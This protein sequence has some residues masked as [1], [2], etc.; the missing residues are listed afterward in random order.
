M[1]ARKCGDGNYRDE[2]RMPLI[3]AFC[4][5]AGSGK[6]HS[7]ITRVEEVIRSQP[8]RESQHV[9]VI[10]FMHGARRQLETRFKSLKGTG[11]LV[12]CETI[13]SFCL[14]IINHFRRYLQ[15]NAPVKVAFTGAETGWRETSRGWK[16]TLDAMRNGMVEL[17]DMPVV[18]SCV[19]ATYPLIVVDEFQDCSTELLRVIQKLA[20]VS[21]LFVA[22]DP[23]QCLNELEECEAVTW[24]TSH[25][26][27]NS[28]SDNFRTDCAT[29][30][31]TAS[32]LRT[33]VACE[34][35]VEV[36]LCSGPG[37]AAWQIAS[38]LAWGKLSRSSSR[39]LLS[40]TRPASGNWVVQVLKSL[41]GQLGQKSKIGPFP[42]V[43]E[44]SEEDEITK[45]REFFDEQLPCEGP[46][47]KQDLK[48][49]LR[50]SHSIV[51]RVVAHVLHLLSVRGEESIDREE[52]RELIEHFC[53]SVFA[54]RRERGNTR[55]AMTMHGAK[56]REFDYVFILWPHKCPSNKILQR[57]LLYNAVTRARIEAILLVQGNDDRIK[58]NAV[59]ELVRAGIR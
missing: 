55:K 15:R 52:F 39:V 9:L 10:T 31:A 45:I 37:L 18:K 41:D 44:T 11:V 19:A 49:M 12:S 4:G 6:T 59:L 43:W 2:E 36:V 48:K 34:R 54:Y 58:K 7:L 24:L 25:A 28:L 33:G 42:F 51:R 16:V 50:P 14:R 56:N 20:D 46:I 57:K 35:C 8:P 23:F 32:G 17:L 29:L 1:A 13:D 38:K 26:N 22:A 47:F 3:Q 21:Q 27:V 30:R 40:P 53:H 5:P